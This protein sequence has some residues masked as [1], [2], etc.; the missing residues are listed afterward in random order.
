MEMDR[1]YLS[2]SKTTMLRKLILC[3]LLIVS[4]N[5]MANTYI[6]EY[7]YHAGDSDSKLT[8][9]TNAF[10]QIKRELLEEIGTHVVAMSR[11]IRNSNG[12][13][14]Y[15][16]DVKAISYGFMKL[17]VLQE[18]W[19]GQRYTLKASIEADPESIVKELYAIQDDAYIDPHDLYV[20]NKDSRQC[21]K[22]FK[23]ISSS[24]LYE[25]SM[26]LFNKG[27]WYADDEALRYLRCSAYAGN[28]KAQ[29][30]IY[31]F[32]RNGFDKIVR[33]KWL[34]NAAMHGDSNGQYWLGFIYRGKDLKEGLYWLHKAA[35]QDN[36][37]ALAKLAQYYYEGTP[38]IPDFHPDY[39]LAEQYAL[40]ALSLKEFSSND[41]IYWLLENIQKQLEHKTIEHK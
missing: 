20:N 39:V 13:T 12:Y 1:Q 18:S 14:F 16:D 21:K 8:S 4:M 38:Y 2:N 9:R 3:L 15:Q 41:I 17:K 5:S 10:Q 26:V 40:R 36:P 19:D 34:K 29:G 22:D 37:D 30:Y 23:D 27:D 25:K 33:L 7:T 6:R 24:K 28:I 31:P 35:L 11:R 32:A